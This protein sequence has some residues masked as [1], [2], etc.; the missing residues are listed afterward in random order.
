MCPDTWSCPTLGHAWTGR[1]LCSRASPGKNTGVGCHSLLQGISSTQG[2]NAHLLCL[3]HWQVD[4]LPLCHLGSPLG[5]I[6]PF[7]NL[8]RGPYHLSP[9]V[10]NTTCACG[11]QSADP[12]HSLYAACVCLSTRLTDRVSDWVYHEWFPLPYKHSQGQNVF[13]FFFLLNVSI[14]CKLHKSRN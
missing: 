2:S 5:T 4:S 6:H 7:F 8:Q 12:V 13:S 10:Q 9:V 11:S 14:D 3:L 1:L